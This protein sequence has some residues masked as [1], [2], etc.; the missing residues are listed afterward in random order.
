MATSFKQVV[1]VTAV[2]VG[3]LAI[4]A[5][6]FQHARNAQVTQHI[7]YAQSAVT[8]QAAQLKTSQQTIQTLI[9]PETGLLTAGATAEAVEAAATKVNSMQTSADAYGIK[10]T[11]LPAEMKTL[12][13]QRTALSEQFQVL[14]EKQSLQKK[15]NAL[16]E[17]PVNWTTYEATGVLTEKAVGS[18]LTDLTDR[19]ALLPKDDWRTLAV[20]YLELA[21]NQQQTI[22]EINNAIGKLYQ[23]G[24]I[25]ADVTLAAFAKLANEIDAVKNQT[26]RQQMVTTLNE[27]NQQ[28]AL[29]MPVH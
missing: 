6:G 20:Q 25:T 24:K 28:A 16:Y 12:N 4:C 13:R 9:D 22:T 11:Q 23:N 14:K 5:V 27:I 17:Q 15:I 7:T 2:A 26:I 8:N 1:T 10:A 3:A 19:V 29:G 21:K 18:A